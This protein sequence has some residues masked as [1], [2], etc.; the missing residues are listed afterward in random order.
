MLRTRR[1]HAVAV[2]VIALVAIV[3]GCG[4]AAMQTALQGGLSVGAAL[5]VRCLIGALGL[6]ILLKFN[7]VKFERASLRDGAV[8]GLL[9]VSIFWLQTDGLRFTTTAKSGLITSL[10]VPFTPI[11]AFFLKDRVKLAHGLGALIATLG[12]Y[13]LVHVPG[14]LWNG[15]NRGDM[16]T[17]GSAFLCTF[18]VVCTSRFSRRSNAWVLAWTQVAITGVVSALIAVCLPAPFGFQ[19]TLSAL[20][21]TDVQ[22]AMAFMVCFTTVFGFWGISKMQGYLSAT[23]AAVVYSFE[24]LV[25]ALVGVFWVGEHFLPSQMVG[26]GLIL[27]AM[28]VAEFLPRVMAR[29]HSEEL[30]EAPAD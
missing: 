28:L 9:L 27:L 4:F 8:L 29:F 6:T 13:L 18:H 17:L 10:Y 16:E 3:F 22:L 24:P 5:A 25:A 1:Q 26:A 11:L 15:W 30:A 7:G 19:N 20:S 2:I 23:E 21:R 12:M 14:S